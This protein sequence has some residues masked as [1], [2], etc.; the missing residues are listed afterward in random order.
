MRTT[1]P[2]SRKVIFLGDFI[3]RGAYQRQTLEIVRP[4]IDAGHALALYQEQA[5]S[6][7]KQQLISW[8]TSHPYDELIL[9]D[10]TPS[11]EFS[12]LYEEFFQQ[13]IHVIG[14]NKW[15]AS[16]DTV[17][18]K[19]LIK[20]ADKHHSLWL[21]NT[22]V[23]AGL[24]INFAINDLCNSGDSIAEISGI[25]SGTLSWL[26]ETFDGSLDFS[27]LLLQAQEQGITEP[28]P[29]EDL[30]GR[31]VQRKLLILA[32]LAGFDLDLDDIEVQ[33]LVPDA[34]Q[35]ISTSEFLQRAT[36]LDAYFAEQVTKAKQLDSCIRYIARFKASEKGIKAVVSLEVLKNSDAF[37]QITPCD[38][39]F[40]IKSHWYQENPLIIRGPGAG[41]DVTAGGLHSDLVTICQQLASKQ[42]QVKI[43]GIN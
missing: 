10:I 5:L 17:Q 12:L 4:M 35:G 43:K 13:G 21:G 7:D 24:P 36:E 37:S 29:R 31:D 14:A 38:N 19:R 27:T 9:V 33:N 20:A 11:E 6:Y 16:S 28:D 15:A 41:R 34:L 42:N 26:F 39:I 32:R 30:S 2:P 8:L 22:T 25:F 23:G 3:D 1:F 18:Y 40:Q